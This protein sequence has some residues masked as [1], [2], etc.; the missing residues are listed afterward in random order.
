MSKSYHGTVFTTL[1]P[2]VTDLILQP[3]STPQ[4]SRRLQ[5]AVAMPQGHHG[6]TQPREEG[7]SGAH[8]LIPSVVGKTYNQFLSPHLDFSPLLLKGKAFPNSKLCF[9]LNNSRQS[10]GWWG[11]GGRGQENTRLGETVGV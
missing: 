4:L 10:A 6:S 11:G 9:K 2:K 1:P 7:G 3:K 5:S 8:Y